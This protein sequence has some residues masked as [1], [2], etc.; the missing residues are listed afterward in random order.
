LRSYSLKVGALI[1]QR[2]RTATASFK[3][4]DFSKI[5]RCHSFNKGVVKI[6]YTHKAYVCVLKTTRN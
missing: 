4:D 2:I 1:N 3:R 5:K 6:N